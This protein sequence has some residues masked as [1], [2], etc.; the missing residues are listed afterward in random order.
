MSMLNFTMAR[1]VRQ[2]TT[3]EERLART[4]RLLAFHGLD[5]DEFKDEK[6][7]DSASDLFQGEVA[8]TANDEARND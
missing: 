1:V 4:E 7:V 2:L 8:T 5:P 3:I 6:T